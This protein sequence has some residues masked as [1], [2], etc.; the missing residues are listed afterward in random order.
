MNK[1][2]YIKETEQV[3]EVLSN[4]PQNNKS[5][6]K[7][8][9]SYIQEELDKYTEMKNNLIEEIKKRYNNISSKEV[10]EKVDYEKVV[11]QKK[12]IYDDLLILNQNNSPY[13]KIGLDKII[14]SINNYHEGNLENLNKEIK[15]GLECFKKAGIEL[16][17]E[18]FW[19]SRYLQEY[20][21]LLL[22]GNDNVE[23]K[24][25][26]NEIYWK[27]PNIINQIAMNLNNL[28]YKYEKK[29]EEY[30]KNK[31]EV[32]LA[33]NTK[34]NLIDYYNKLS[35]ILS[36]EEYSIYNI[37][38]R[39]IKGED[40][41]KD[42]SPEKYKSYLESF[43]L[44]ELE[45]ETLDK[46]GN[47]LYEYKMYTKYKFLI[48]EY[49][50]IYK[51]KDKYKTS[52]K[53]LLKEI[54][55]EEGKI[56]KIN[57]KILHQEKWGKN[58]N[59]IEILNINLNNSVEILKEKYNDLQIQRVNE[60]TSGFEDNLSYYDI[61]QVIST[62]Y[63]YLR[64][65][66]VSDNESITEEEINNIQREL[67]DFLLNN[68]LTILDNIS[69]LD[70]SSIPDIISNIYKLLNINIEASD[71]EANLDSYIE[72]LRKINIFNIINSSPITYEELL[73]QSDSQAIINS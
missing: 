33:N 47:T 42:F 63:V 59:K 19:Y 21:E 28:Y 37:S 48:E 10:E 68:K 69:V 70:E 22:Q 25:K 64:K 24:E 72:L 46:L 41:I 57:K 67:I 3:K 30:Y 26:L 2:L 34:K 60:L 61:L 45:K 40:S 51:E 6:R 39:M 38:Q 18:E 20:M 36:Q 9:L 43:G 14:Y 44:S 15:K 23:A 58:A 16:T 7:K 17:S 31:I 4:M 54:S 55:K 5:N 1:D 52:Y 50:K 66:L 53:T 49:I 27:S 35:Q 12:Q 71:I 8:Y 32:L 11:E 56:R 13:E 62:H 65:I 29:F 73:F